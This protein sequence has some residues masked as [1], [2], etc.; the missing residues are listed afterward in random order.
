MSDAYSLFL[1]LP[2]A[3]L[4]ALILLPNTWVNSRVRSFRQFVVLLA[5]L[6]L[7]VAMSFTVAQ[8]AGWISLVHTILASLSSELPIAATVYYDG[9]AGLMLTLVSFVGWVICRYSVRYLDGEATQGRYFRWTAFTIGSVSLMVI[10]GN[11][12]MFVATWI[13][14]SLGLHQLLMH[15]GDHT[16]QKRRSS[17]HC[18]AC[19]FLNRFGQRSCCVKPSRFLVGALGRSI[20][21]LGWTVCAS[22]IVI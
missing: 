12:L 16:R 9:V 22:R 19:K 6:Q 4:L 11:L 3:I 1:I 15:Y 21:P 17:I 18:N 20:N 5:G 10:S 14:T 13:M 7:A 2:A 8:A